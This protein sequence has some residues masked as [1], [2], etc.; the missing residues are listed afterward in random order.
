MATQ[1]L[2]Y[3]LHLNLCLLREA[4]KVC[5]HFCH[6]ADLSREM[7]HCNTVLKLGWPRVEFSVDKRLASV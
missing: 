7:C 3:A 6:V 5:P 2:R 4:K 1:K